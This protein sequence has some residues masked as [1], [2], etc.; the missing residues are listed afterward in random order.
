MKGLL[1]SLLGALVLGLSACSASRQVA[2]QTPVGPAPS[3]VTTASPDGGLQ[4]FSAWAIG[5]PGEP[6][7]VRYHSGYWVYLPDGKLLRYIT[8]RSGGAE[9]MTGDPEV[10]SLAPGRYKV[11]ARVESS[12]TAE[13]PVVVEAGKTSSIHL[14]GSKLEPGSSLG[15][16]DVVRLP[17]GL[18][19]GWAIR[20]Q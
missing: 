2:V 13:I 19:V 1:Y 9:H 7:Y 15:G 11:V 6:A 3:G 20:D 8:N 18:V 5:T 16:S 17:D 4:V 10:V 14:D 12:G